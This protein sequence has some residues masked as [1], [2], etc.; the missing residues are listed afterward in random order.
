MTIKDLQH[1]SMAQII[2]N[3]DLP[4]RI[5]MEMSEWLSIDPEY[6]RS[7]ETIAPLQVLYAT[8][9]YDTFHI[10]PWTLAEGAKEELIRRIKLLSKTELVML[11]IE[12]E[13]D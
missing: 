4:E 9:T 3:I 11:G 1:M 6:V 12:I 8:P 13:A 2:F 5:E 10:A 7:L